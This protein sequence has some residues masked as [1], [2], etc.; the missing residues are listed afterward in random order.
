[1]DKKQECQLVETNI[2]YHF[3]NSKLGKCFLEWELACTY[4]RDDWA[5]ECIEEALFGTLE[6]QYQLEDRASEHIPLSMG[7]KWSCGTTP[8]SDTSTR[9][10]DK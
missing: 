8:R 4:K 1:M 7:N 6:V 3:E 2:G 5:F 9:R 10:L